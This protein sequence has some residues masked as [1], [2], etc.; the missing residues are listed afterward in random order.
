MVREV[1]GPVNVVGLPACRQQ[2]VQLT[3]VE[4]AA[5]LTLRTALH[6][7]SLSK[8]ASLEGGSGENS[9][10]IL[11][12]FLQCVHSPLAVSRDLV[13]LLLCLCPHRLTLLGPIRSTISCLQTT[14]AASSYPTL[15]RT[16][17]NS[18]HIN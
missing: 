5:S 9:Q 4:V 12:S 2:V 16:K 11:C 6:I 15:F 1:P 10:L 18:V 13:S 3:P 8:I 14:A 17:V 7:F